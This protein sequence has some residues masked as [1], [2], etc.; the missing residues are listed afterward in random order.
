LCRLRHIVEVTGNFENSEPLFK[1]SGLFPG[2]HKS[3]PGVRRTD[4]YLNHSRAKKKLSPD[5]LFDA[6]VD[7]LLSRDCRGDGNRLP[8]LS[9]LCQK[10]GTLLI[11]G[12]YC[13][14][15]P[16]A[17]SRAGR[18]S[19]TAL[20]CDPITTASRRDFASHRQLL[21]FEILVVHLTCLDV[22]RIP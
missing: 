7:E 12:I 4:D 21:P 19:Q 18:C 17:P 8:A 3:R 1:E 22:I 13:G 16:S 10:S 9:A 5:S 15:Q 6:L 20:R 14:D 2:R 11:V